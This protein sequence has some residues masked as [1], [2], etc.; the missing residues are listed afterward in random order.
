ML[1]LNSFSLNRLAAGLAAMLV[2]ACILCVSHVDT[3]EAQSSQPIDVVRGGAGSGSVPAPR[4]D[5]YR[6]TIDEP[7]GVTFLVGPGDVDASNS[8]DVDLWVCSGQNIQQ[9]RRRCYEKLNYTTGTRKIIGGI[10]FTERTWNIAA[11][12][13]FVVLAPGD[14]GSR[15]DNRY[16]FTYRSQALGTAAPAA[17]TAR[18]SASDLE[19]QEGGRKTYTVALASR[20]Q[21]SADVQIT[22][23][24]SRV[25]VSDQTLMFTSA[26]WNRPQTV[27]ISAGEDD[28]YADGSATISHQ[29]RGHDGSTT[30]GGSINVTIRD[31]DDEP[32]PVVLAAAPAARLS[33]SAL[34]LQEGGSGA[35]TVTLASAP[36]QSATVQMTASGDG[37][38]VS[39]PTLTFTSA[40]WNRAQTVTIS[41]AEDDDYA[42]GSA[43]IRHRVRGHDGS[44]TDS[45]SIA[46]TVRDNDT[47]TGEQ[48]EAV[49]TIVEEVAASVVSNVTANVGTRFSSAGA[50]GSAPSAGGSPAGL[51]SIAAAL[52]A[53]GDRSRGATPLFGYEAGEA[54]A[55]LDFGQ[56]VTASAF[57]IALGA[58]EG[59]NG[60]GLP[61]VTVWGR[62]DILFFDNDALTA[63]YDGNL[64]AGYLGVDAWLDDRTLAGL[65]ASRSEVEADYNLEDTGAG[66]LKLTL[67]GA[68]PYLRYAH[69]E[70]G[71]AW[72]ILGAGTGEIENRPADG[73]AAETSDVTMLM[74]A[75][76]LRS[77]VP[78]DGALAV[79]ALA[80]AGFGRLKSDSEAGDIPR[81]VDSLSVN[82]WRLRIGVEVSHPTVLD[83]GSTLAPFAEF[84]GRYDRGSGDADAGIEVSG[85][86]LFADPASG[87]G[88]EARGRALALYS[89]GDYSEYGASLTASL[90]PGAGGEGL[91]FSLAPRFG[92]N[93]AAGDAL[94]RDDPFSLAGAGGRDRAL[95]LGAAVG[96]GLPVA[97]PRGVATPFGEVDFGGGDRRFRSG[98]RFAGSADPGAMSVELAGERRGVAGDAPEHRIVLTGRAR[99]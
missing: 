67:T 40:N 74:A 61:G 99:F 23:S 88:V 6:F 77:A 72:G 73:G 57:E 89:G 95:A 36:Q 10:R 29:V 63:T 98:L 42:D 90:S 38:R 47:D 7:R 21:R 69:R 30:D 68:H 32:A 52:T 50:G 13:Y 84:A 60:G 96:Y 48:K 11:G 49:E 19:L 8:F 58:A 2:L 20:P 83:D 71:E 79:A 25:T 75:A 26:N 18:L 46:V 81:A 12:D 22:V 92:A 27:T 37:V 80:D 62:G 87:F 4:E 51:D 78:T 59:E 3:A 24:G 56:M 55:S 54:P 44:T 34:N 86:V 91:S 85:G 43:T 31:N 9:A 53:R 82:S 76:G 65:A 33:A 16:A 45:G 17:P 15:T 97:F 93:P 28:D 1:N 70:D 64:K 5:W 94:W 14:G 39:P 41:A 35:Y 66:E